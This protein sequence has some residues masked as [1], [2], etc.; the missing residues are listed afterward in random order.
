M[1][2]NKRFQRFSFR[3]DEKFSF[4]CVWKISFRTLRRK[5]IGHR[6]YRLV[7]QMSGKI[8]FFKFF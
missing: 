8:E 7:N 6:M 1:A 5:E 4:G 2:G 3:E